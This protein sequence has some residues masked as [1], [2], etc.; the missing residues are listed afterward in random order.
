MDIFSRKIVYWDVFENES[1]DNAAAM[2][3]AACLA[4]KITQNQ[5][6]LHSDNGGPMKGATMLA[7]LQR[8][9]I[10]PSFSRPKVSN[11]NPYSEALFKT[12]K[13][14]PSFPERGF[15]SL[16]DAR[17][18]VHKFVDWYNNIHLHS[19]IKFVTPASKHSGLDQQIL[20]QRKGVYQR[21]KEKNPNRWSGETRDWGVVEAVHLNPSKERNAGLCP[22][23]A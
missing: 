5:I 7:T 20:A 23:A 21:A 16:E 13:Y 10:A 1:A 3:K 8:L 6:V 14:C 2:I 17:Q 11:D 4:N 22:A 9:G 19:G 15:S 18:W 12:M